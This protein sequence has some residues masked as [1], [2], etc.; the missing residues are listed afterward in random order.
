[1]STDAALLE[2][3]PAAPVRAPVC[4]GCRWSRDENGEPYVGGNLIFC[5]EPGVISDDGQPVAAARQRFS[6][7][8]DLLHVCGESAIYWE[9]R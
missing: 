7:S 6:S 9:P 3:P 1:M 2:A 4:T 8:S 5:A